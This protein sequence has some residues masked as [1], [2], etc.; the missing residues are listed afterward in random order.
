MNYKIKYSKKALKQ[1]NK[2]DK[3]IQNLIVD[4]LSRNIDNCSN[5]RAKGKSLKENLS[6]LWRYRV[7]DYRVIC[8]IND[9]ELVVLALEI[10]HRSKVYK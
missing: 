2:M 3:S 9:N 4:W 7:K 5:P 10:E 1:L 8:D 6:G